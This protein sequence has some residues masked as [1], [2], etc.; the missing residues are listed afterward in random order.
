MLLCRHG[1]AE[2]NE[3][4]DVILGRAE[5]SPLVPEGVREATALGL[6]LGAA[7]VGPGLAFCS[8]T[9]RARRTAEL[10]MTA[11]RRRAP[12]IED[13]RLHEQNVGD[14]FG[15]RASATFDTECLAVIEREGLDFRPPGGESFRDVGARMLDWLCDLPDLADRPNSD[16]VAFT[17]GGAIRCLLSELLGWSHSVTYAMKP[18]NASVT[19][20]SRAAGREWV[21]ECIALSPA[22]AITVL[23]A[24]RTP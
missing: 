12:I 24:D 6:A 14:W 20:L 9:L 1:R 15:R 5:G 4:T 10:A 21:V 2:S 7:K 19:A 8:P 18:A 22:D 13:A 23:T 3:A 17:H 11:T 16:V